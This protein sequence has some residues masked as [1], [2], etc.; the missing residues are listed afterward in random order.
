MNKNT[1]FTILAILLGIA[2]YYLYI[3][4]APFID[5]YSWTRAKVN[6]SIDEGNKII[7]AIE[8]YKNDNGAL[9]DSLDLLQPKYL[10]SIPKPYG[11]PYEWEYKINGSDFTLR[12]TL[13]YYPLCSYSS[14]QSEW[15]QD[16][17]PW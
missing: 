3:V 10:S 5:Y 2:L 8:Q 7:I 13:D 6:K 17:I 15:Y 1:I 4:M 9:P 16:G 12:V 11:P 14:E